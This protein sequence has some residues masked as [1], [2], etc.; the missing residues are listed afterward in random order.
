M[1]SISV[2]IPVRNE[3]HSIRQ[4]L[5]RLLDQTR[6]SQEIVITDGGSND[7]TAQII[8]DFISAGAPIRLIRAGDALPGR[9]RNLAAAAATTEWLAF[10]DA[11]IEP[12]KKWIELLAEKA[13]KDPG[14][15]VVYGAW[16]PIA[17]SFFTECAAITYV[18]PPTRRSEIV[19]RPRFIAS[20][21]MKKSVWQ[22][23]DGFSETLRSGE[24]LLF[25]NEIESAGFNCVF[26]PNAV[27]RWHLRPSFASTFK[28]FVVYARNNIRAGLWKQ[29]QASIFSRY[30]FLLVVGIAAVAI[31]PAWFWLPLALWV[32]MLFARALVAIRR[33][34]NCYPASA[35][36]NLKRLL[37]LIPLIATIDL[38]AIVGSIQWLFLDWLRG[39]RK[40]TVEAGN[41]A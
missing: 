30:L 20:S 35:G 38:A 28:R 41:G 9:G 21:L 17:D 13:E 26:E 6:Q 33:N 37:V 24:D 27:V 15:D 36:R 14:I 31:S 23:V 25:M 18:P 3:E 34:R 10:I 39:N 22:S 2:V 4:L 1:I 16:E 12:S 40:A 7:S 11:G 19:T 29:W 32:L 5:V 8:E